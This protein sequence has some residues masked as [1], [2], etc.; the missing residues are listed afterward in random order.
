MLIY[1][2]MKYVEYV[3]L[4]YDKLMNLLTLGT[5]VRSRELILSE[6]KPNMDVLDIGCGTGTL[7]LL[8]AEKGAQVV[9]VDASVQML[10]L[11]RD[12]L[13]ASSLDSQVTLHECGAA[14]MD[15]VLGDQKFDVIIASLMLGELPRDMRIKTLQVASARLKPGGKFLICDEFWPE[16]FWGN[17]IYTLL[18]LLFFIPNFLF[19]RTLIR[20]LKHFS[21]DLAQTDL[22]VSE[23]EVLMGGVMR[24][25]TLTKR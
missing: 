25:C 17:A 1:G 2:L 7:S 23:K 18:F 15:S 21:H 11:C 8:A 13:K 12:K 4:R 22:S 24:V 20:P 16:S 6:I 9:G 14:S 3:P 10:S 5:H 19:T